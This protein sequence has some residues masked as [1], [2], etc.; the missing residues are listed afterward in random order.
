MLT[1]VDPRQRE[2]VDLGAESAEHRGQQR[3]RRGEH[4]DDREHDPEGHRAERGAV[5][6]HD[7]RQR[8][9]DGDAAEQ[10][11]LAGGVHG[12]LDGVDAVLVLAEQRVPE[13]EDDE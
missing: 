11:G 6:Q 4:E 7:R 1:L 9:E 5:D 13:A 2:V 10:D 8:D 3:Q 12:L